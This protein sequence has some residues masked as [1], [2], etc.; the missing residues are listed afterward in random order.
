VTFVANFPVDKSDHKDKDKGKDKDKTPAGPVD[1]YIFTGNLVGEPT[2]TYDGYLFVGWYMDNKK[3]KD[4]FDFAKAVD[5]KGNFAPDKHTDVTQEMNVTLYGKWVPAATIT[6]D[7]NG[8]KAE[9][10]ALTQVVAVGA[11]P[12]Y[13]AATKDGCTLE[14]WKDAAGVAWDANTKV[15][16]NAAV[17]LTAQWE[18]KAAP[19]TTAPGSK[20]PSIYTGGSVTSTGFA[21]LA[22]VVLLVCAAGALM[23]SR[24]RV[25]A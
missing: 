11:T 8:G 3:F 23:V 19:A 13:P 5:A 18:C 25:V 7:L 16:T 22:A 20:G 2:V 21:G 12:S 10:V 15:K 24:R 17:T 1:Q 9:G 4:Q 6:F 14:G